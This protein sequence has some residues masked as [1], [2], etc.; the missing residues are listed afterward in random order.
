MDE[1]PRLLG[2][3]HG[4]QEFHVRHR[5]TVFAITHIFGENSQNLREFKGVGYDPTIDES[6]WQSKYED[7]LNKAKAVLELIVR[8]YYSPVIL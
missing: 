4:S 1:I 2:I 3:P 8:C 5:N 7:N 6:L